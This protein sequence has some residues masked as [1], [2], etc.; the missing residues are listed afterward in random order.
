MLHNECNI[1]MGFMFLGA[2][3][4]RIFVDQDLTG[5]RVDPLSLSGG[6][7]RQLS[8]AVSQLLSFE[9]HPPTPG[10]YIWPDGANINRG[11]PEIYP[12]ISVV[13]WFPRGKD[14]NT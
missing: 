4:T 13:P 12:T 2:D 14:W 9:S 7:C 11:S 1:I 5:G 8:V 3:Q 6:D 10:G